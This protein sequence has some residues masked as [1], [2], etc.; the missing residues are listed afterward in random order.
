[1]DRL[2]KI[3]IQI[4]FKTFSNAYQPLY[5]LDFIKHIVTWTLIKKSSIIVIV[6][7]SISSRRNCFWV[8]EFHNF[9]SYNFLTITNV[10]R[11]TATK[12]KIYSVFVVVINYINYFEINTWSAQKFSRK[13]F[14]YLTYITLFEN[15][16]Y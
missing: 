1:M 4:S 13:K 8:S 16:L 2:H 11:T 3:F 6:K 12:E 15:R 9:I 5:D 14:A 7:F 10:L